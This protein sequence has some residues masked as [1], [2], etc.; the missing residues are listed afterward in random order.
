[1]RLFSPSKTAG[2]RESRT[3]VSSSP[4][5]H[6]STRNKRTLPEPRHWLYNDPDHTKFGSEAS[7][8]FSGN[9]NDH[10]RALAIAAQRQHQFA[11]AIRARIRD[12]DNDLTTAS[13][14]AN[15]GLTIDQLRRILRGEVHVTLSDYYLI[16][17][18]AGV[19]VPGLRADFIRET[20]T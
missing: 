2:L 18:H 20:E 17:H 15:A 7:A 5:P 14:A 3:V 6:P 1:M 13:V 19:S 8:V 4:N 12:T 10:D 16:A 9:G 11:R